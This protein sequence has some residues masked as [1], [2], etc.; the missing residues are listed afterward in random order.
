MNFLSLFVRLFA[1]AGKDFR[2]NAQYRF[3]DFFYRAHAKTVYKD[4]NEPF[5]FGQTYPFPVT[6]LHTIKWGQP[7]PQKV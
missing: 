4:T 5:Q 2:Q 6:P 1:L 3:F 7:V